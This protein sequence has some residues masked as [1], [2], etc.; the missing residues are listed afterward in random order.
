MGKCLNGGSCFNGKCLCAKGFTG[1]FCES[2]EG[3]HSLTWLWILL[4]LALLGAAGFLIYKY[5]ED[6]KVCF[7][8]GK[9]WLT[10]SGRNN[11]VDFEEN[12]NNNNPFGPEVV[13]SS[14][15]S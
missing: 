13:D 14:K 1:E 6:L 8:K 10:S 7:D 15:Q 3:Q 5:R 9:S 4:C 2:I 11:L 12:K